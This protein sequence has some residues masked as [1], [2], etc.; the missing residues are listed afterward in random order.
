ME[1]LGLTG[2]EKAV[3]GYGDMCYKRPNIPRKE[4]RFFISRKLGLDLI[5]AAWEINCVSDGP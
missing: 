5:P 3:L 1:I 4:A 2:D